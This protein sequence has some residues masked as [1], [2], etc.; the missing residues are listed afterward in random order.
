M[1][2]AYIFS[3]VVGGGILALS[4][5]GDFFDS[6]VM[7]SAGASGRADIV[8]L[9]TRLPGCSRF[10]RS[11]LRPLRLRGGGAGLP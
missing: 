8:R 1:L 3:V 7:P 4:L 6:E 10:E 5:F 2:T 9:R 11:V